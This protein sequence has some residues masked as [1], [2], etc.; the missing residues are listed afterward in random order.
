MRRCVYP[1]CVSEFEFN[2]NQKFCT[3]HG[4]VR[5]KERARTSTHN[6]DRRVINYCKNCEKQVPKWFKRY[7][8]I[9][10]SKITTEKKRLKKSLILQIENQEKRLE[11]L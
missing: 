10:C 11:I 7:C 3:T 6:Q 1:K 9:K 2:S 4:L 8:S 5:A